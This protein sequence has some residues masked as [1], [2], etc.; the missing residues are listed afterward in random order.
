MHFGVDAGF[1]QLGG[2][3][4]NGRP[5]PETMRHRIIEMAHCG[6]RPCDISRQLLVSHGCVNKILGRFLETGSVRPGTI[7]G[8]KPKVATPT[9]V[10]KIERY[11]Q[12]NP[13]IFAWEIRDKL[14]SEG[15]CTTSTVPSVSSINRILRNRAAERAA[16]EYARATEQAY[17]SDYATAWTHYAPPYAIGPGMRITDRRLDPRQ[18]LRACCSGFL[19][20]SPYGTYPPSIL[21]SSNSPS[22]LATE[23]QSDVPFSASSSSASP[24]P[25]SPSPATPVSSSESKVYQPELDPSPYRDAI[26]EEQRRKLRRSRTTFTPE[27]IEILEKEFEKS[28]YPCVSTRED[29]ANKTTLSEARVWFSNRRAKWRRHKKIG[30]LQSHAGPLLSHPSHNTLYPTSVALPRA[31]K[32]VELGGGKATLRP[33]MSSAFTPLSLAKATAAASSASSSGSP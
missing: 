13:T 8:S 14:I 28:H 31:Y 2:M 20:G 18:T 26:S 1:N 7:G 3:F 19:C 27:Q 30:S 12:E 32:A 24:R 4:A 5:L 10:E 9:V 16:A 11:K 33:S 6:A 22:P 21:P 29:L 25:R 15:V 17:L 23:S